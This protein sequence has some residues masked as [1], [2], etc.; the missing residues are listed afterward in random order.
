MSLSTLSKIERAAEKMADKNGLKVT[1]I[2]KEDDSY[3]VD[4][5][6]KEVDEKKAG[7]K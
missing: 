6:I 4:F 1:A 3:R 5:E 2:M 7:F